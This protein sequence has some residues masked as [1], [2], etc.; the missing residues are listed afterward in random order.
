MP[1]PLRA[2]VKLVTEKQKEGIVVAEIGVG[3]GDTTV[4][5]LDIVKRNNGKVFAIDH[6][7]GNRWA[8]KEDEFS[9]DYNNREQAYQF[10]S[11]RIKP[12][13][14]IVTIFW[15]DRLDA[16]DY[17]QA[18]SLD[19]CFIDAGHTYSEVTAD[20]MGYMFKVKSGGIL[21]GHDCESFDE[22]NKFTEKEMSKD[23]IK[24]KGLHCG[25]I[26]AVF[27][28]FGKEVELIEDAV[29]VKRL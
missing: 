18:K 15:M 22:V 29:W 4:A 21:C 2:F 3:K 27:D 7:C 19:I 16:L 25:V 10:F 8:R 9:W 28:C 12:W 14:D 26:Q 17:I 5:Y 1:S 20:I 6:F 13:R 23:F 24:E 11:Q